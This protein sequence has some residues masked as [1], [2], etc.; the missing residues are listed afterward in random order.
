MI[1]VSEDAKNKVVEMMLQ[2]GFNYKTDFVRV[3]V[4][5]CGC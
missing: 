5:S 1:Q 2:D 3:G 4:K